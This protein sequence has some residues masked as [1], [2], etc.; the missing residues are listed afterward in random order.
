VEH[1]VGGDLHDE[2]TKNLLLKLRNNQLL[3]SEMDAE[4]ARLLLLLPRHMAF[5]RRLCVL[6]LACASSLT[7]CL[8]MSSSLS[9]KELASSIS[10]SGEEEIKK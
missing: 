9:L 10:K 4:R 5:E 8:R 1:G 7:R 2:K 6:R 3:G